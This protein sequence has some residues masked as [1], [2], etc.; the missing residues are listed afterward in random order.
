MERDAAGPEPDGLTPEEAQPV[1]STPE[2]IEEAEGLIR[3]AQISKMRGQNLE[4]DRLLKQAAEI[5]PGSVAVLEAVGDDLMARKQ[6]RK[7]RDVYAQALK[8]DPTNASVERKFAECI[9]ATST[10]FDPMNPGSAVSNDSLANA[11]TAGCLS[12]M[13]PGL[14]QIVTGKVQRGVI[15]LS[16]VVVGWLCALLIPDGIKGLMK[17]VGLTKEQAEFNALVM[18]PLGAAACAH[19]WSVMDMVTQAK[20]TP[21]KHVDRPRPPVDMPFE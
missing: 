12:L 15:M 4:A 11:K 19:L 7:A 18:L 6:S 14:G 2:Q 17:M 8:I 20:L 21:K 13:I 16:I 9:L 5:A 3:Q 10:A 1:V